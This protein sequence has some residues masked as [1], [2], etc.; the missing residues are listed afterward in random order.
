MPVLKTFGRQQR[1]LLDIYTRL[2]C[3]FGTRRWWPA[4]SAEEVIIGAILTQNT[5][6]KNVEQAVTALKIHRKLSFKALQGTDAQVL[7]ELIRPARYLNQK[8]KALKVFADYFGKQYGYSIQKMRKKTAETLRTELLGLC[9]IGP[10]TADS[11]LL[12][13]LEKPV[14]VIDI[15]TKRIFSRHGFLHMKDSYDIYQ[16]FFMSNLS[17][18]VQ[19]Y[20]EYHAQLVYVGNQFCKPNP[21]CAE[22]PLKGL[23]N[24]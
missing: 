14:F 16:R 17:A 8:A 13:A 20:N 3:T 4:D 12:Y 18:D 7:A 11:I 5:T 22:C 6:W 9:R 15:Y 23:V 21:R 2:F 19:L 24:K 1:L 10:E